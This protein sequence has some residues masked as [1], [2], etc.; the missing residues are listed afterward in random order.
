MKYTGMP[1]GMWLIFNKSFRKN[2]TEVLKFDVKE[3]RTITTAAKK[4]IKSL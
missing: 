4:N 1:T 3:S 2:L